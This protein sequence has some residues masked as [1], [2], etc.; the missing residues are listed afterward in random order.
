M[1][2]ADLARRIRAMLVEMDEYCRSWKHLLMLT[3]SADV[4]AYREWALTEFERQIVG[5]EPLSWPQYRQREAGS[6]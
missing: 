3:T 6:C 1:T 4:A 5:E 2:V